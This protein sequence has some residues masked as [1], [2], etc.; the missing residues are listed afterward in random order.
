M[1]QGIKT[2]QN[3]YG[4]LERQR[5]ARKDLIADTRSINISST[6]GTSMLSVSTGEDI[7]SYRV[8]DIAHRQI[9]DRLN[10][11]YKYYERMRTDYPFL[12]DKNVNGWLLKNHERRM[13]RTL[14]GKLRTFLSDRYR[15]LDNLEIVGHVL[16]VIAEMK[17]C[18]IISCDITETHLYLKVINKTMKAEIV[19]GDV[20]QAGFII[21]NS[22]IGLG[23]L[24]VEPLVYRLVCK[25]GMI[26]KD[27]AHKKYHTGKLL[28]AMLQKGWSVE[29]YFAAKKRADCT[30]E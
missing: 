18:E 15:R 7:L 13:L 5:E 26:S 3:L 30:T 4:E 11:P 8:T 29:A 1:K 2:I 21:S 17:G 27:L 12:L 28:V 20:V 24:K 14:D 9:A 22:E 19:P 23:A 6:N 25:N 10:I 16:P